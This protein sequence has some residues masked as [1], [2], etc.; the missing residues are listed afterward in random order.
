MLGVGFLALYVPMSWDELALLALAAVV[1]QEVYAAF[2]LRYFR[3]RLEPVVDWLRGERSAELAV[4]AWRAAVSAPFELFRQWW[5]G[6]YP[7]VAGLG[8]CLFATWQLELAAW[9]IPVLYLAA[10]VLLAYGNGLAFFVMERAMQPVLDE[11][12]TY[13]SD[14][15]EAEA[16]SLPL[17]RRLL[18]AL[19]ALNM[20]SAVAVAGLME[21]GEPGLGALA[22]AVLAALTVAFT[23]SF[24]LSLLLAASVVA[25]IRRLQRATESVASGELDTRVPVVASDETGALT[26]AFNRMVS[27]LQERERIRDAFGT[28]VDPALA[29]RVAR[30]GTDL[31]GEEVDLSIVFMDVRGFTA[32]SERAPARDVVQ[33]LTCSTPSSC[34]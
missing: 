26:R 12:S 18:A 29:E 6:G 15:V 5:R 24:A 9:A 17:R 21:D 30:D 28:F 4:R 16:I 11:L 22:L 34:R 27:G 31:R 10:A 3:P 13:L 25:P 1:A 23:F 33:R 14:D 8:W 19:P 20:I 2:T 32:F 7:V